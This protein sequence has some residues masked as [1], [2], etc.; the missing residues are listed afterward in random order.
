[1]NTRTIRK[2]IFVELVLS[3]ASVMF[4]QVQAVAGTNYQQ[5][6]ELKWYA[7]NQ[8]GN[9]FIVGT[10]PRGLAFDGANIWVANALEDTVTKVRAADGANLGTFSA[11]GV[12]TALAFDGSNIWVADENNGV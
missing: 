4:G 8:T 5:I 12:P 7:A 9:N 11:G 6:A 3:S 1:M 10:S 2:L